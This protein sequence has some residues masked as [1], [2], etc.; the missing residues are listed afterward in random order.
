MW[1]LCL[2]NDVQSMEGLRI[3]LGIYEKV[4]HPMEKVWNITAQWDVTVTF[5]TGKFTAKSLNGTLAFTLHSNKVPGF[6]DIVESINPYVFNI[7]HAKFLVS[8][9]SLF[10]PQI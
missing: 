10:T 3:L 1:F 5:T 7:F 6:Q 9:F 4:I 8:Y 2:N